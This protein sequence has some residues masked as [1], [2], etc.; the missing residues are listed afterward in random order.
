MIGT[1]PDHE[2]AVHSRHGA[3]VRVA[4]DTELDGRFLARAELLDNFVRDLDPGGGLVTLLDRCMELH[5]SDA[6][7][8][9]S[10]M[11]V[12]QPRIVTGGFILLLL[13]P[14]R[15]TP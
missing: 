1:E 11:T 13:T 15:V 9:R 7:M 10:F 4:V 14:S 6:A 8:S 12:C 3:A 5:E 2:V